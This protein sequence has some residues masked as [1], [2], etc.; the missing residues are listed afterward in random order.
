MS[1]PGSNRTDMPRV[2]DCFPFFNELDVLDIRLSELDGLVD[3]FVIVEATRTHTGKPK[4][5]YYAEN[6]TRFDR[7]AHKI[8]HVVV[9]DFPYE[10]SDHWGR[11]IFQRQAIVR[12]LA[13]ARPDDL[14]ITS[15][16]DEIPKPAALRRALGF[17]GM[18]RRIVVFWCDNYFYRLNLRNDAH[19]HRLGPRLVTMSNLQS[20]NA[21]REIPFRFSSRRYLRPFAEP[22]AALRVAKRL[23]TF[24]WPTILW[25]G[26]W[27]FTSMG[28]FAALDLK[29]SSVAPHVGQ[30]E[31]TEADYQRHRATLQKCTFAD[32]PSSA[33][34]ERF[35][36]LLA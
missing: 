3:H 6:R 13:E 20:P 28:D 5:L 15:D 25:S 18:S 32:L 22:V 34:H 12:G 16:C 33:R 21:V 36:H 24:L 11:E 17:R 26:A 10:A 2:F 29:L 14:I 8:I 9:D 23:R 30:Q 31:I 19:D 4:P 27:H 1:S 7:Y 35:A